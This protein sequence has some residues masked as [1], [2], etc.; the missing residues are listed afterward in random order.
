VGRFAELAL[1]GV[2]FTDGM[3]IGAGDLRSAWGLPGRALLFGFP[4][5]LAGNAS[6]EQNARTRKMQDGRAV[7]HFSGYCLSAHCPNTYSASSL[8][9]ASSLSPSELAPIT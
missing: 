7:P 1:F 6:S 3:Q 5:T 8:K 2:L 4:L 9:V